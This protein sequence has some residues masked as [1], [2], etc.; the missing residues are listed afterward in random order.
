MTLVLLFWITTD[1]TTQLSADVNGFAD[2]AVVGSELTEAILFT[3]SRG[4]KFLACS[5]RRV[6]NEDDVDVEGHTEQSKEHDVVSDLPLALQTLHT[7]AHFLAKPIIN[8][9]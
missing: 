5:L 4:R 1:A 8:A 7:I 6:L 2:G 3:K 9:L